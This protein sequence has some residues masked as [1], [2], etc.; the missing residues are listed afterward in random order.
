MN[1]RSRW[2][3]PPGGSAPLRSSPL[4]LGPTQ[5]SNL[6]IGALNAIGLAISLATGSHL[7]LDL[8]GTGAFAVAAL[9]HLRNACPRIRLGSFAVILWATRLAGFLFFRAL[10]MKHDARLDD[11]LSTAGGALRFWLV[12]TLWGVV[13]ALPYTLGLTSAD[14]GRTSFMA[15]GAALYLAG[16]CIESG[17]DYQKW[18]FKRT[19]A[20]GEFCNVG[21]WSV[22]QHPNYFGNLLLWSGI[23]VMNTPVLLGPGWFRSWKLVCAG[24][25]LFALWNLF[26]GQ[27]TGAIVSDTL[28]LALKKYGHNPDYLDYTKNVPLIIPKLF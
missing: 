14:P 10:S 2:K 26:H 5:T 15:S 4:P 19:H 21:L 18:A 8:V 13:C 25:S 1:A 23:L 12:S 22:S 27:A 17:A 6:I 11:L 24:S 9:P 3:H 28:E 7:H 20:P 16:L